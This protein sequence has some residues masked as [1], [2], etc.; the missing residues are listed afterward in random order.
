MV[1]SKINIAK[2][3]RLIEKLKHMGIINFINVPFNL[4]ISLA[5]ETANER[6]EIKIK[7]GAFLVH[8]KCVLR[9]QEENP[10]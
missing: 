1:N 5:F 2:A 4:L 7:I 3:M 10:S 6:L 8:P 9:S